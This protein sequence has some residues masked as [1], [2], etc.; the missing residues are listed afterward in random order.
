MVSLF[1]PLIVI[2]SL[3]AVRAF[4]ILDVVTVSKAKTTYNFERIRGEW[5]DIGS[6]VGGEAGS[7]GPGSSAG[8]DSG[9]GASSEAGAGLCSGEDGGE[10]GDK[11]GD[12]GGDEGGNGAG[13]DGVVDSKG[14]AAGENHGG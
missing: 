6:G 13:D 3:V 7:G 12:R 4:S 9:A 10:G 8:A 14:G 5:T 1:L 2:G 11:G